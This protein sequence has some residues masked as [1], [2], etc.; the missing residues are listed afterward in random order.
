MERI[1]MVTEP[2][3]YQ[4]KNYYLHP[5]ISFSFPY[6]LIK[7]LDHWD[8]HLELVTSKKTHS[9]AIEWNREKVYLY[10]KKEVYNGEEAIITFG[11][12]SI[13]I[14]RGCHE[15]K[16]PYFSLRFYVFTFDLLG[17]PV[18]LAKGSSSTFIVYSHSTQRGRTQ[19]QIK[20]HF[21]VQKLIQKNKKKKKRRT[22]FHFDRVK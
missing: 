5:F 14:T 2:N 7:N 22:R 21:D 9:C 1:T 20:K 18:V 12:E 16:T 4:T 13:K 19:K 15:L 10:H 17:K 6:H 3:I 11:G 8:L